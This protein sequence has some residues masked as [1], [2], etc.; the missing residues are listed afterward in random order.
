MSVITKLPIELPEK[1]KRIDEKTFLRYFTWEKEKKEIEKRV[2]KRFEESAFEFSP[3]NDYNI[4]ENVRKIPVYVGDKIELE[5]TAKPTTKRPSYKTI[6]NN[7]TSFIDFLMDQYWKGIRREGVITVD[8]EPYVMLYHLRKELQDK[9]KR[10]KKKG[11]EHKLRIKSG[12]D[13]KIPKNISIDYERDYSQINYYNTMFYDITKNFVKEGTKR[14][15]PF[16]EQLLKESL[17]TIGKQPD[18]VVSIT[19]PFENFV[20][21]HQLEPRNVVKYK[22]VVKRILNDL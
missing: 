13:Q 5:I 11:V 9:I 22:D 18:H 14:L 20:F 10:I 1:A 17:H 16:K 15:E 19:Y 7:F 2:I 21:V 12:V 8:N 6:L 3:F 4:P